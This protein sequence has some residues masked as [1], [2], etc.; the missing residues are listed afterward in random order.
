MPRP[1]IESPSTIHRTHMGYPREYTSGCLN[2]RH[3]AVDCYLAEIPIS[4]YCNRCHQH[5]LRHNPDVYLNGVRYVL[6]YGEGSTFSHF[7]LGGV[8]VYE[9]IYVW[10]CWEWLEYT[11]P[12]HVA[13]KLDERFELGEIMRA[14]ERAA[15][16]PS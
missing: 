5:L 3:D 9:P 10:K 8:P 12:A 7:T 13:A 15:G 14:A 4:E 11:A 2:V 1:R 16:W 6:D